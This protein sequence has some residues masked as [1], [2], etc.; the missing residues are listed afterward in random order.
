MPS[1][2]QAL[3]GRIAELQ[4]APAAAA[5]FAGVLDARVT[6]TTSGSKSATSASASATTP[7]AAA[8]TSAAT[9]RAA[10][11]DSATVNARRAVSPAVT[12][13]L[14]KASDANLPAAAAPWRSMIRSAATSA[15]VDPDLLTALVWVE[16]SFQPDAVSPAGAIGLAQL[17]PGTAKGLGVDPTNPAQNLDGAAR[18]LHGLIEQFGRVDH[19]LAAYNVGPNGLVRGLAEG[20]TPGAGYARAVAEKYRAITGR[21]LF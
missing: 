21:E 12:A 4:Q 11:D 5:Q 2:V 13:T 18:M 19:A 3:L 16:S 6:N 17:M 8:K 20:R 14:P 9:A 10:T 1:A 15:G 7:T